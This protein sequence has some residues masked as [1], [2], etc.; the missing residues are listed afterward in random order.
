MGYNKDFKRSVNLGSQNNQN[1]TQLPFGNLREQL[2]FLCWKY[3]IEYLEV[4]ESYTSKSSFLDN[5]ELPE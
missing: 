2:Q 4:E 1:F 5:D 3:G